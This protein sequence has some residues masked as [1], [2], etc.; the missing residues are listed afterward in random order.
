M[1]RFS[2]VRFSCE[3]HV[4]YCEIHMKSEQK[5]HVKHTFACILLNKRPTR[6]NSLSCILL[7]KRPT[8]PNSLSSITQC[9]T[10]IK[11]VVC[12]SGKFGSLKNSELDVLMAKQ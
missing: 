9:T 11:S 10:Y 12:K 3:I 8:G 4:K 7:N 2:C 1:N 6:P 5:I